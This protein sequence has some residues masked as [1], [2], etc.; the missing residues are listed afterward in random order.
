[1]RNY[2]IIWLSLLCGTLVSCI[3]PYEPEG[4]ITT[5]GMLVVEGNIIEPYGT[6]IKLSRTKAL[7]TTGYYEYINSALVTISCDDG[8][9]YT[10][11]LKKEGEYIVPG[12]YIVTEKIT[13]T[14]GATYT[15][16][17]TTE[18]NHYLSDPI[19]PL[20]TPEIE[21]V[22]WIIR[23]EEKQVD[24]RVSTS[25]PKGKIMHYRW[26]CEE[27]WEYTAPQYATHR[28]NPALEIIEPV[29]EQGVNTYYCWDKRH[30]NAFALGSTDKL[31]SATIKNNTVLQLKGDTT[32]RFLYLYSVLVKQY[33]ITR[34]AY[35]YFDNL[36]KNI[37]ETGSVFAPQPTE[38]PGNM[39]NTANPEEVVIGFVTASTETSRRLYIPAEEVPE[40]KAYYYCE[41][42]AIAPSF[43]AM[44]LYATHWRIAYLVDAASGMYKWLLARCIECTELGGTKNKPDW[45]PNDHQ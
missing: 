33:A 40:M 16:D 19:P 27:D 42:E 20:R 15:L 30:S 1:M 38:L 9:R 5:S 31:S 2:K 37:K 17:I 11:E 18:N 34:E 14:P 6:T 41:E 32:T 28:W 26:I 24:I 3:T 29:S 8:T 44:D 43:Q 10:A 7:N 36:Q 35:N 39:H 21:D 22:N 23:Q 13:F 45:W 25:D 12:T 4:I